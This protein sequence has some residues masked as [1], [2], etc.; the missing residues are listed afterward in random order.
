MIC[1][2]F[3]FWC[4]LVGYVVKKI[5]KICYMII[6]FVEVFIEEFFFFIFGKYF[7]ILFIN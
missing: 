2:D 1:F 4:E 5:G 3:V 7:I 6:L